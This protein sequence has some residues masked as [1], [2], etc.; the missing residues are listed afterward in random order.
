MRIWLATVGEPLPVDAG[1]Q[2][3][4]RTGQFAAWLAERGHD[5]TFFTGTMDHYQ[6]RLRAAET[7]TYEIAPNYRI[8]ALAG[9]LYTRTISFARF[10]NHADVARSFREIASSL[11]DPDVVLTSYPT[12]EL[13]RA[14]LDHCQPKGIPVAIDVRDFWPDIFAE[15]LPRPLR[16]LGKAAFLPLELAARRTLARADALSGMTASAM[17]WATAKAG[18]QPRDADFSF[19]FSYRP[20]RARETSIPHEGVRV[21]FLGTLSPRSNLE[22]LIDAF[23]IL[24]G[25]GVRA[26]LDICGSGEAEADL[27]TRAHGLS[28]VAFH[29]WV[30]AERL[31]EIM[32][33]S[34][35]GALPYDRPDF[36]MS[37]PNKCVE[38]LA[39]GLPVLSCTDG[40]VRELIASQGCG[41]WAQSSATALAQVL[42][43]L[44]PDRPRLARL[45]QRA[46]EVFDDIFAQDRVFQGALGNLAAL[47]GRAAPETRPAS[48]G[49]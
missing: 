46:G 11:P 16:W 27:R 1:G 4:L 18:R 37:I 20:Q 14:I 23:R 39:G 40:E 36:H 47:A 25:Q 19:P 30:G 33:S 24:E 8:V 6:R 15:M 7:T 49:A 43:E 48:Q 10:R 13:C 21:C 42:A 35:L 29:G 31:S 26:T 2:R 5:V 3:L 38:Y 34:D 9:R 17:R 22:T 44:V 41:I 28:S 45:R 12:E 32:R